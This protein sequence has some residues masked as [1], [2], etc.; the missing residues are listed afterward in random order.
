MWCLKMLKRT[1]INRGD[2]H[3]NNCKI[4]PFKFHKMTLFSTDEN[5]M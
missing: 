1:D 2:K 5:V 3:K 4:M